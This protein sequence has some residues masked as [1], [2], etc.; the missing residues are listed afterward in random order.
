MHSPSASKIER[1]LFISLPGSRLNA[2]HCSE[3]CIEPPVQ[4]I[5]DSPMVRF[6]ISLNE[7]LNIWGARKLS[8][9][10]FPDHKITSTGPILPDDCR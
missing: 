5:R 8:F 4:A 2:N 10:A 1:F 3:V 9:S 6:R 7:A